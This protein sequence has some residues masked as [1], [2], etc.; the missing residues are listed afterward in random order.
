MD[1]KS[2]QDHQSKNVNLMVDKRKSQKITK[3]NSIQPLENTKTPN[4]M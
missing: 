3:H 2:Q 4:K 1:H